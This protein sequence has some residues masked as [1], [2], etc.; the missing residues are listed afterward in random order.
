MAMY[1]FNCRKCGSDFTLRRPI[2]ECDDPASCP[3]C[4]SDDTKRKLSIFYATNTGSSTAAA[5]SPKT[6]VR[7]T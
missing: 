5:T 3:E 6:N 7:H 1:D 2:A 4:K